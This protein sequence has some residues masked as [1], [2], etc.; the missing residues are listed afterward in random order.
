[1]GDALNLTLL[2]G[3]WRWLALLCSLHL[4]FPSGMPNVCPSFLSVFKA[5]RALGCGERGVLES[6]HCLEANGMSL[7]LSGS[8]CR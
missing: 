8:T 2:C 4:D 6:A 7:C 5:M 1:M 3:V